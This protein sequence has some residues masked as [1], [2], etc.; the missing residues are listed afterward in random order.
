MPIPN[1]DLFKNRSKFGRRTSTSEPD[2]N[3]SS[4]G[5]KKIGFPPGITVDELWLYRRKKAGFHLI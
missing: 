5:V 1:V 2:L 4:F 3:S